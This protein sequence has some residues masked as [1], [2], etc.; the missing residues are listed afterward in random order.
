MMLK[1]LSQAVRLV[2]TLWRLPVTQ[3]SKTV[4]PQS[5][6]LPLVSP[7]HDP[8]TLTSTTQTRNYKVGILK[9]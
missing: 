9:I 7:V 8:L 3:L 5:S 4:L 1:V 6:L 2:P